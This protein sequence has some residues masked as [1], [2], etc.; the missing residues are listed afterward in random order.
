MSEKF[1]TLK[2]QATKPSASKDPCSLG[3]ESLGLTTRHPPP[4]PNPQATEIKAA[5][6]N[7]F[8]YCAENN[9]GY[10]AAVKL[11]NGAWSFRVT[12]TSCNLPEIRL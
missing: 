9:L 8:I 3:L 12:C 4:H 2:V 7:H 1:S 11:A 5:V 10:A 6:F